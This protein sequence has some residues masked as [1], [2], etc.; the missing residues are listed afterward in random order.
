M[1]NVRHARHVVCS[2]IQACNRTFGGPVRKVL[3]VEDNQLTA[4]LLKRTLE[5]AGYDVVHCAS[6]RSALELIREQSIDIALLD[7]RLPDI[8]G[9]DVCIAL[10]SFGYD[11]PVLMVTAHDSVAQ[12]V[13]CLESGADDYVAKPFH[14]DEVLARMSALLRRTEHGVVASGADRTAVLYPSKAKLVVAG[15]DVNL[16]LRE[17]ELI[18]LLAAAEG[19]VVGPD[20]VFG[21]RGESVSASDNANLLQ[22]M[23]HNIRKKLA[24]VQVTDFV[25]TV[26]GSGY[27]LGWRVRTER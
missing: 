22:V 17:V 19:D 10:R 26:R 3:V 6:G 4:N 18:E 5:R 24:E 25:L 12:R 11:F 7:Y 14:I 2:G 9:V 27:K 21:D 1:Y 8:A 20:A 23:I 13:R 16:T 15:T